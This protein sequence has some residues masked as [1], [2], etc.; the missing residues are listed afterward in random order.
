MRLQLRRCQLLSCSRDPI[1]HVGSKWGLYEYCRSSA[2]IF[3]DPSGECTKCCCCAESIVIRNIKRIDRDGFWNQGQY[4]PF[5]DWGTAFDVVIGLSYRTSTSERDCTL[6]WFETS[7]VPYFDDMQPNS[8]ID[9]FENNPGPHLP[10]GTFAPW[11]GPP[12]GR[13]KPCPGSETV[14]LH[15]E[16][17]I[18]KI[19]GIS[20]KRY[21]LIRIV[22]KSAADCPCSKSEVWVT[23]RQLLEV[24]NGVGIAEE[25]QTPAIPFLQ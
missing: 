22:V 2:L 12:L 4:F 21:L 6:Q 7:D 9:V 11:W 17:K 23:A 15:D 25:F 13:D 3:V 19:K 18:G 16:P 8:E 1:G 20:R 24:K 14:S 5:G 10:G